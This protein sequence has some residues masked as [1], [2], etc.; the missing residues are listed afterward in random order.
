METRSDLSIKQINE[1]LLDLEQ[2][3]ASTKELNRIDLYQD[4]RDI[5]ASLRRQIAELTEMLSGEVF[6]LPKKL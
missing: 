4:I 6:Y 2:A 5:R 1:K 3:L